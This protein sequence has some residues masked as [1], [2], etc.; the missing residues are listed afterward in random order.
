MPPQLYSENL[1]KSVLPPPEI[2]AR[3][4]ELLIEVKLGM[5]DEVVENRNA[6]SPILD[7]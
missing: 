3:T 5:V 6:T 1:A 7:S 2:I 4:N